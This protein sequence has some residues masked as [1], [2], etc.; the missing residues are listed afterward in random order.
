MTEKNKSD[1]KI[2]APGLDAEALVREVQQRVREK[3]AS[4]AYVGYDLS[5]I[6]TLDVE[7]PLGEEDFLR[8]HLQVAERLSFIKFGDFEIVSRGGV[9]GKAG[10]ILKKFIWKLLRFYTYRLFSQQREFNC[11]A[12]E[13]LASHYRWTRRE[14]DR[15]TAEVASLREAG[16]EKKAD[17]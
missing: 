4:G 13:A 14:I 11:Q 16:K 1:F 10:V 7:Q 3:E 2:T 12:A 17:S 5:R 15:L 8:Y 6:A 9:R